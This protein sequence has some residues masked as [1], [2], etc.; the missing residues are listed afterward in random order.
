M[1]SITVQLVKLKS[2]IENDSCMNGAKSKIL[3]YVSI[4]I[5]EGVY[6]HGISVRQDV[7]NK[8]IIKVIFPCKK[9]HN[10]MQPFITFSK[11]IEKDINIEILTYVRNAMAKE[12]DKE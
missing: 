9:L 7:Q 8:S 3:A 5:V 11:N 1:K 2:L 12:L 4:E 6:I 10:E